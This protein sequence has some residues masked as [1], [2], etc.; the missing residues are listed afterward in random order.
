MVCYLTKLN[1]ELT[2]TPGG[3]AKRN[4]NKHFARLGVG[5]GEIRILFCSHGVCVQPFMVEL[6]T[7]SN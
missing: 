6:R 2:L 4:K 3:G 1:K 7:E 5:W